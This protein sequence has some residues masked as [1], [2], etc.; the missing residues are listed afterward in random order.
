MPPPC[1]VPRSARIHE[2]RYGLALTF[3]A[4]R[5]GVWLVRIGRHET[6]SIVEGWLDAHLPTPYPAIR[7]TLEELHQLLGTHGGPE[8]RSR[9]AAMTPTELAEHLDDELTKIIDEN[10][11]DS[12]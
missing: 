8:A 10:T 11:A 12:S 4:A 1:C 6:A 7:S 3:L 2:I 9:G 5:L